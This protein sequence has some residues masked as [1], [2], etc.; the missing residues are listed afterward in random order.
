[1]KIVAYMPFFR[2]LD[3]LEIKLAIMAPFV[4]HFVVG[5]SQRTFSGNCKPLYLA[6]NEDRFKAYPVVHLV[7]DDAQQALDPWM[8]E[9]VQRQIIHREA[10]KLD[11]DI[12]IATD[13]DEPV[14]E[15]AVRDFV[16]NHRGAAAALEQ[17][18]LLYYFN[19]WTG[20]PWKERA[21]SRDRRHH[22]HCGERMPVIP[23]AGWHFSFI[24][25]QAT[26]LDKINATAHAPEHGTP[27][28][29]EAVYEGRKPGLEDTV[30]YPEE[31]LPAF[32]RENR[33]RFPDLFA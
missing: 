28:Y 12:L 7:T 5:E 31:R 32:V 11:P 29:F 22:V 8:R 6:A 10:L 24:T 26:L 15:S 33:A 2:E 27:G 25:D 14:S 18:W 17:D 19:R 1:M 4:D 23:N 30:P 16:D 21:I 20:R 3:L 13:T 9:D